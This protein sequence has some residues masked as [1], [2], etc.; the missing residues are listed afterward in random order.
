MTQWFHF[1]VYLLTK[2]KN[3]LRIAETDT[4]YQTT[5]R[6]EQLRACLLFNSFFNIISKKLHSNV[7]FFDA[8]DAQE[9]FECPAEKGLF[10][11]AIQCDKFHECK[12]WIA[13]SKLCPDGLV[14]DVSIKRI[15]KCDQPFNVD[16]EDRIELRKLPLS[17]SMFFQEVTI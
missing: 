1:S 10:A 14:F 9:T 3:R 17:V 13:K 12:D 16:C 2:N 4:K 8:A 7:F 5:T 15:S 6:Q 11:D